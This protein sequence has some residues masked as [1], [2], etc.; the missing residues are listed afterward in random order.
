MPLSIR[1][2]RKT[3]FPAIYDLVRDAFATLPQA[4]GDEQDFVVAM[5]GHEGYIPELALVAEKDGELVG[6]VM[7]TETRVEGPEGGPPV[8]LLAPLCVSPKRQSRGVGAALMHEAFRR[9]VTLGYDAVFLAGNPKYYG[10]FGFRPTVDFGIGHAMPVPDAYIMAKEL[11]PGALDG[12]K[13]TILLT[14]HTTCA[15]AL[16]SPRKKRG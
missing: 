5:R 15:S 12:R 2:E 14:G 11:V 16:G 3:D 6:Y 1:P 4:E 10:R 8:L 13:G 7:L 9:A